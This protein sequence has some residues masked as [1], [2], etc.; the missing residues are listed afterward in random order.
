MIASFPF[1]ASSM[2]SNARAF[3]QVSGAQDRAAINFFVKGIKNLGLYDDMVCWPLRSAQ[4]AGTGSTAYSLGGLG[5]YNGTLVNGPTWGADGVAF[6]RTSTQHITTTLALSGSQ[7][8]TFF[9]SNSTDDDG[10]GS[11]GLIAIMG[12]RPPDITTPTPTR[13][14]AFADGGGNNILSTF[15]ISPDASISRPANPYSSTHVFEPITPIARVAVNGGLY[16]SATPS[17]SPS[18]LTQFA[19]YLGAQGSILG[20]RGFNGTMNFAAAFADTS[21]TQFQSLA[22]HNLYKSTLGQGL[23]LP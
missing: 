3:C 11:G 16:N 4:N 5:T 7:N 6:I 12:A 17:L 2:D 19:L 13:V 20:D 22:L 1:I 21:L 15:V 10:G 8:A 23:G 14:V 18:G 9:A